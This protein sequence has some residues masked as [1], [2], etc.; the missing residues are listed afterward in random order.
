MKL[1]K[2]F[3]TI[4]RHRH[5]VLRYC[6]KCGLYKQG[7]LHD[8]SK[9][10]ITE[11]FNGVKYYAGIYSPHHNERK[12]KGYSDAWMHHKGR[13]KHHSE[14][15]YDVNPLTNR[16]EAVKMPDRYVGEMIC[17]RIAAS[18][19][20]NR[21]NYKNDIPLNYFLKEQDRIIMHNDTRGLA[22]KLLTMYQDKGEKYTFK[23]IKKNLR[24]N[25]ATY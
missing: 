7:L 10:G 13:N 2:H 6:F 18:K 15:W 20:Y 3:I 14:Y 19:N 9:Y 24:H 12:N 4:T 16:Y 25:K 8:L 21:K 5:M 11:F 23:Y 1:I 17:D 22:L